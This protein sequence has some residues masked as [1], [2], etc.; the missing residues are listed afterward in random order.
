MEKCS[1]LWRGETGRKPGRKLTL[2]QRWTGSGIGK[3][4]GGFTPYPL[5]CEIV[6]FP[7]FVDVECGARQNFSRYFLWLG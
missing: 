6:A 1:L 4:G 2:T 7:V 5:V 3:G